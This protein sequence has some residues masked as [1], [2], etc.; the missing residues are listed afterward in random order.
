MTKRLIDVLLAGSALLLTAPLLAIA[1]LAVRVTLGRPV[2]FR[3]ERAGLYGQPFTVLKLRTMRHGSGT[4]AER[5]TGCGAIM[6]NWSIDELPQLVNVLRGDMSLVGPRPLPTGYLPLYNPEQRRRHDV[7]PGITGW[8]Q[9]NGRNTVDWPERLAFD[10][11]YVERRNLRFDLWILLRTLAVAFGRHG[12]NESEQTP[13][14]PFRGTVAAAPD[15]QVL[16][17]PLSRTARNGP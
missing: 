9:I 15:S 14:T 6:R 5:L 1:A 2:L 16:A 3:Q 11:D 8:A 4:D 12:V 10:I 7:R 17:P 13:M